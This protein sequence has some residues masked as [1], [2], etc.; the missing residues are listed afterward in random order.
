M[1]KGLVYWGFNEDEDGRKVFEGINPNIS[2]AHAIAI[3]DRF[4]DSGATARP[5]E[6]HHI[7]KMEFP[8]TYEV[9]YDPIS[10]QTDGLLRRCREND[11]CPKVMHTDGGNEAWIKAHSLVVTDSFGRDVKPPDNV[12][13][14]YFAST[15]H[16]PTNNP[17]FGICQQL[18]NPLPWAPHLK[19]LV[20]ALDD[21][22][23]RGI[24][25]PKS[26]HPR[27]KDGTFAPSLPQSGMGFPVI[28]GVTYNGLYNHVA[29]LDK[30]SLPFV[31]M[32]GKPE[33]TVFVPTTDEDGNDIAGLRTPDLEVP[34]GTHTGLGLRRA[35]FAENEDCGLDGQYIP[36]KAT[37]AERLAAGDPRLS[38]EE[39]YPD[40][41][42]YVKAVEKAAKKLVKDRL[43]LQ[44]DADRIVAAADARPI[45]GTKKNE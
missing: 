18:D 35:P 4:G 30:S 24:E 32:P 8:F 45:G 42:K 19:A 17:S 14:F 20:V 5:Y 7:A 21:W 43:L 27:V 23:T 44:E 25:P 28:P 26:R 10:D 38:I 36:F 33:Y 3:N 41:G 37:K 39:R 40:H 2:G 1:L 12:R 31:H 16:G 15:Q 29:L 6:R 9:L 34:L 22:A 11:T 13:V